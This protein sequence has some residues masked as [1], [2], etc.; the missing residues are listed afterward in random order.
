MQNQSLTTKRRS[1]L[2]DRELPGWLNGLLFV[3]TVLTILYFEKKRPLRRTRREK[4]RRNIRNL[5]MGITTAA[6][7]RVSAKPLTAF[8]MREGE[9]RNF[10][11]LRMVRMPVWLELL[12]SV[13]LLDYTL[14][15]WHYLT[16]RVPFLWRLH[17]VHHVDLDM[18]ASTAL[19]FHPVEMLV[20]ASWRGAQVFFL[21]ISPLGLSM[22]QIMTLL[23]ILFHHS[24]TKLPIAFERNLVRIIVTPR[25]HGIH[26]SIVREEAYS[27]WATI[28]SWADYVHGTLRLNIPQDE[29]TI[30]VPAFQDPEE[31]TLG[32][33]LKMVATA[34]RPS[35]R[36][37]DNGK[38]GRDREELPAPRIRLIS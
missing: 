34:K 20:S 25:M 27:N 30:G 29:I 36:L 8:L 16:H 33:V 24:N 28:F 3:G 18:D 17:Q 21:G 5:F 37:L 22:W 11:L 2:L 35:W 32:K 19:R 12:L 14:F 38:P 23:E 1:K 15:V 26:H 9:W 10:G 31:L 7:V 13:V 4:I 6:T